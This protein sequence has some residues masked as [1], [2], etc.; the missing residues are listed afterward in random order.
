[1]LDQAGR[2]RRMGVLRLLLRILLLHIGRGGVRAMDDFNSDSGPGDSDSGAGDAGSSD[3][4]GSGSDTSFLSSGDGNDSDTSGNG[5]RRRRNTLLVRPDDTTD[6][7]TLS[8]DDYHDIP[9]E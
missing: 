6:P 1:M 2:R 7:Q 5:G 8:P 9:L 3:S 4:G